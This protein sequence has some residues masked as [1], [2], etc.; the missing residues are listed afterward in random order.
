MAIIRRRQPLLQSLGQTA[1]VAL[2]LAAQCLAELLEL[3]RGRGLDRLD[4]AVQVLG[5]AQ[6]FAAHGLDGLG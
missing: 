2:D 6:H 5:D 4:P 1:H 3:E